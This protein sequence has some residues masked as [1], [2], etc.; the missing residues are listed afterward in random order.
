MKEDVIREITDLRRLDWSKI[1]RSSG[2]GGS[3]LKAREVRRGKQYFYKLSD[4]DAFHGI[5][6]HEC[7]NEIIVDRL[8]TLLHIPHLSYT[9][10]HALIS[11]EEKEYETWLCRSEDFRKP[12]ESKMALDTYYQLERL[13]GESPLAFCIRMGWEDYIYQMLVTDYLVLNRDRHGANIEVLRDREARSIRPAPL[14]DHGLS[15]CFS[16]HDE[17]GL[18]QQDPLADKPVQC[19]VG[20]RSAKE[21]LLLI[22]REKRRLQGTLRENDRAF[23]FQGLEE[24]LPE[25]Y[26][27]A[28]W[29]ML[30]AR[31]REYENI[32]DS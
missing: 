10:I 28:I 14:F 6:G 29:K 24:A 2:T 13:A 16:V 15:F 26:C 17:K 27:D 8:L 21:N 22:P 32:C 12:G 19:F 18:A 3:F 7:V 30:L 5:V 4:F 1:R 9:L 11:I 20:S 25:A 31:W 23:L